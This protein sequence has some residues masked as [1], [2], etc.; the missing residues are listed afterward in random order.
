MTVEAAVLGSRPLPNKPTVSA[1]VKQHSTNHPN[2]KGR[3][4]KRETRSG[5]NLRHN[6]SKYWVS[7][8]A[9]KQ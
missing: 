3:S 9:R 1:D 2:I 7:N 6:R 8:T 4:R 5:V